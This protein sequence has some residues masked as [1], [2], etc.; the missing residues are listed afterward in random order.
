MPTY[1]F[2]IQN[3]HIIFNTKYDIIRI[4]LKGC[5]ARI[6]GFVIAQNKDCSIHC[7][8]VDIFVY[9]SL[10]FIVHAENILSIMII[11]CRFCM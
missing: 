11:A 8:L 10:N 3:N 6:E 4:I 9:L 1:T 2:M 5:F 7:R